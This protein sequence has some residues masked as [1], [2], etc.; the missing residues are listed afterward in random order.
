M[1]Y[2][3]ARTETKRLINEQK[4][5]NDKKQRGAEQQASKQGKCNIQ[6]VRM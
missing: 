6:L 1:S 4:T 3:D 5:A 2:K